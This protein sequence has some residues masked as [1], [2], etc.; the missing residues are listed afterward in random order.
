MPA[1]EP[2]RRDAAAADTITFALHFDHYASFDALFSDISSMPIENF[3]R[4]DIER[5]RCIRPRCSGLQ[6]PR[7]SRN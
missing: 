3:V 1:D 4:A 2:F 6:Q 7:R 5:L